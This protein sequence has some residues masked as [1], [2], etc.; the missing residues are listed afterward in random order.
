MLPEHWLAHRLALVVLGPTLV[1]ASATFCAPPA[2]AST[3]EMYAPQKVA[4]STSSGLEGLADLVIDEGAPGVVLAR[5]T[6]EDGTTAIARG[7]A[8]LR[9]QRPAR[10]DDRHRIGSITKTMVAVLVL[11]LVAEG[12]LQLDDRVAE[13]LP[14]LGID[15]RITVRHVLQQTSGFRTDT[16]VFAPPRSYESNRFR[17]FR[18]AELIEIALTNQESRPA[19]GTTWQY[20]NT[21]YVLAGMLIEKVTGHPVRAELTRRL[22]GPLGM[23]DTSFPERSPFVSGRH[24]RGYL[25]GEPGQP[26]DDVTTYSMSW[27]WTAGAVISTTR[28]QMTFLRALFTGRLLPKPL[29]DVMMDAEEFGYGLG[30]FPFP[31]SCVPGGVAWGHDGVVFG[32][33]TAVFSTPDGARQASI[34]ANTWLIDESGN[35][36]PLV[37]RAAAAA[38]CDEPAASL[39]GVDGPPA[40]AARLSRILGS[41]DDL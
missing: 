34:G 20:S 3:R 29:L 35:L 4:A 6:P 9:T 17:Y 12:R 10:P 24:L 33:Q 14:D 38:L 32:Y 21:N 23:R 40:P 30:L 26:M 13:R 16:G 22:F 28:D 2:G 15:E 25:P 7:V 19:P 1:A 11:Q 37:V 39:A 41:A 36:N 27:A 18:P 8:D 31:V 5:R